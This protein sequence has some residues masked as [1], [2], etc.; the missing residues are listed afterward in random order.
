MIAMEKADKKYETALVKL[1]IDPT[2]AL[3]AWGHRSRGS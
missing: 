1:G 3:I 2:E